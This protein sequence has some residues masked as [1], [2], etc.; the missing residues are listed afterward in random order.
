MLLVLK[1]FVSFPSLETTAAQT[2]HDSLLSSERFSVK[3]PTQ[4]FALF[5]ST[6]SNVV[7]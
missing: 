1:F 5:D 6:F 3:Y 2:E 4:H 7:T